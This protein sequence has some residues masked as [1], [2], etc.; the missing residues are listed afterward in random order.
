MAQCLACLQRVDAEAD[1]QEC[2][3]LQSL[4]GLLTLKCQKQFAFKHSRYAVQCIG[5]QNE[6][7]LTLSLSQAADIV[8]CDDS[9]AASPRS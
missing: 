6:P 1:L 8:C 3:D 5:M 4:S 7:A 9:V 2:T